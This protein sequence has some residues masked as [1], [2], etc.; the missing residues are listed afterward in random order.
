MTGSEARYVFP[1]STQAAVHALTVRLGN[2][3]LTARMREKLT[4][5]NGA[6]A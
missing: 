2:R 3:V 6:I 4:Q 5:V 1:G